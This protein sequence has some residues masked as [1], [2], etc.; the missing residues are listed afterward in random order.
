MPKKFIVLVDSE[1]VI[2]D[3]SDRVSSSIVFSVG[4]DKT[5]T[6]CEVTIQ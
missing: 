1:K 5:T 4:F 6:S 2:I 3:S